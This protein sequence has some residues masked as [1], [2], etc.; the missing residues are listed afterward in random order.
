M[1]ETFVPAT[2]GAPH[3][4]VLSWADAERAP[5]KFQRRVAEARVVLSA[6]VAELRLLNVDMDCNEAFRLLR[7]EH[8]MSLA[9]WVLDDAALL[10]TGYR[11]LW[12]LEIERHTVTRTAVAV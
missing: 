7:L 3:T 8:A 5:E 4:G 9:V 1:T 2:I 10:E 6:R 12:E 11:R